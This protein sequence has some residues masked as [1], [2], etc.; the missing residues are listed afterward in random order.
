[1]PAR[2]ILVIDEDEDFRNIMAGLL[3]HAGYDPVAARTPDEGIRLFRETVP[4]LVMV[5]PY[6]FGKDRWSEVASL[7]ASVAARETPLLVVSTLAQ[8]GAEPQAAGCARFLAKPV[9]PGW[10]LGAI[11][12][13]LDTP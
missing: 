12:G 8:E 7:A 3:R 2:T 4:A 1:M 6:T 9:S 13:L 11:E 10:V 5:E